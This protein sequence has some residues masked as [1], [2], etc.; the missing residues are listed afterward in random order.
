[1]SSGDQS[2]DSM[3]GRATADSRRVWL[4]TA[5]DRRV[6]TAGLLVATFLGIVAV[7]TL[8]PT[9]AYTLLTDGDPHETLFNALVGATITGVTLVLTLSQLVLSQELGAVGDQ[10]DRMRG[11]TEFRSDAADAV[12]MD[13]APAEPS[14]FLRALVDATREQ[15]LALRDAAPDSD[16]VGAAVDDLVEDVTGNAAVTVGRL[17][18]AEFGTFDVVQAA[19]SYNYSGKLYAAERL[20]ADHGGALSPA[21]TD[22]LEELLETLRLF[23]PAREHFKTL[24]FQWEL[25]E[26]SRRLLYAAMPALGV[27]VAAVLLFNPAQYPGTTAG[28][29]HALVV[30]SAAATVAVAPFALLLAYIL[31]IVTVT[32]RTLSIGAF[33]LRETDRPADSRDGDD[34]G[35]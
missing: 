32:K 11:A 10:R 22:A 19:L 34:Y 12:G 35:E 16:A 4:A 21:A 1:M 7:G 3:R 24:Y 8:L 26:L 17:D 33:V 23:G 15:A 13:V 28:V 27:S 2:A 9:P 14:A 6:V 31:R 5:A 20:R 18:S 29:S 25:S 30:V